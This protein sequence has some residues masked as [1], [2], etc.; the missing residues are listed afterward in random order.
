MTGPFVDRCAPA[1]VTR[2]PAPGLPPFPRS[3]QRRRLP[4]AASTSGCAGRRPGAASRARARP[5]TLGSG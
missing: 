3:A 5:G 1:I 2:P 4:A